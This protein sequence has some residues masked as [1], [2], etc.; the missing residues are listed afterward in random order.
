M[1][2]HVKEIEKQGPQKGLGY[3]SN[4]ACSWTRG[5]DSAKRSTQ[6]LYQSSIVALELVSDQELTE[7]LKQASFSKLVLDPGTGFL[8][9]C[10]KANSI[11]QGV[12]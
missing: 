1:W 5:L 9:A 7:L 12:N 8:D 4:K 10:S 11:P 2:L 3:R 6:A